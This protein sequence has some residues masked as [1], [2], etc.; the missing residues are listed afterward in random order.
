M[1]AQ[2]KELEMR[3]SPN[4]RGFSAAHPC[5]AVMRYRKLDALRHRV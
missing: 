1:T 3:N 5:D 2:L 4:L